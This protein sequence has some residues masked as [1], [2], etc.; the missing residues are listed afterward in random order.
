MADN[1]YPELT[2]K[3]LVPLQVIK[4]SLE[5]DPTYLSNPDCPYTEETKRVLTQVLSVSVSGGSGRS[6]FFEESKTDSNEAMLHEID[7]IYTDA[8]EMA[9]AL[10]NQADASDKIQLLKARASLLQKMVEIKER[11]INVKMIADFQG[12][13]VGFLEE[14][15]SKDQI[16]DLMDRLK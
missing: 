8:L 2:T 13:V 11:T 5:R 12:V 7:R 10:N 15:C 4:E 16:S 6:T 3:G 1:W 14:I 9:E